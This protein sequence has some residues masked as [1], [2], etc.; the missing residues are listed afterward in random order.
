MKIIECTNQSEWDSF[1][2]AGERSSF[3]QSWEWG[4][5]Q[6]A[7][8]RQVVRYQMVEEDEVLAAAQVLNYPF[9]LGWVYAFSPRGPVWGEEFSRQ[10]EVYELVRRE[11]RKQRK[12]IFW[13]LEPASE[14]IPKT[15][16]RVADVQP[17]VTQM[18]DLSRSKEEVLAVMK[19]KTRYNCRL[20]VKKG[21][22]VSFVTSEDQP[23]WEAQL[24]D[25]WTLV[26][27]TSQRHGIRHHPRDYYRAMIL[28]LGAAGMLELVRAEHEGDLLAMNI[29]IRFGDT[30][31]YLH[32]ASTHEK[33]KKLMAPYALQWAAIQRAQ[34]AG[35]SWYD[36]YGVAPAGAEAHK[37]S[38]VTRFK[39]GFGGELYS[40]PG[41]VDLPLRTGWYALYDILKKLR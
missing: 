36:F 38:G 35:Y 29:M 13:R 24:D 20:A 5:F 32:G 39:A 40:Y 26:E 18:I 12:R 41:T 23:D 22:V 28:Q 31:T 14:P 21:V 33:K 8:G 34:T 3:L 10:S 16:V 25:F 1:M 37:L 15:A 9:R 27:E 7:V 11:I 30:V 17:A 2:A 6:A 4:D 19:Q